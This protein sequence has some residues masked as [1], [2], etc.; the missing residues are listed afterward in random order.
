MPESRDAQPP[1]PPPFRR[2]ISIPAMQWVG[3]GI[4]CLVVGVAMTGVLGLRSGQGSAS[5]GALQVQ[6][7]YPGI[8][9]YK[10][11]L[12]LEIRVT[13]SGAHALAGVT[14]Q[15]DRRYLEAFEDV[16]LTPAAQQVTDRHYQ[17]TLAEL[18]AGATREVVAWLD[19]QRRGRLD[20]SVQVS[21]GSGPGVDLGWTTTVLP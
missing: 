15:I 9:R 2:R 16:H 11:A 5:A 13:N 19:A 3:V 8:M 10:T 20:A 14:V 18:P 21:A 7:K 4:L 17:V 6:V 12:P 1:P